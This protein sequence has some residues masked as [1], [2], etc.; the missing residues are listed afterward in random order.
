MTF[1]FLNSIQSEWLK[2][3]HT[4]AAWIIFTCAFFMPLFVLI[5]RLTS[6]DNTYKEVVNSNIWG[7]MHYR[8]K[9]NNDRSIF[10]V[11]I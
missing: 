4:A 5:I 8:N 7:I 11:W 9:W 1:I 2:K 10:N 3:R 6:Y